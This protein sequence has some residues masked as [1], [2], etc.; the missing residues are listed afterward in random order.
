MTAPKTLDTPYAPPRIFG[1]EY[2]AASLG[3]LLCVTLVA[4]EGMSVGVV[5]PAISEELDALAC[6]A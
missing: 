5:M 1:S 6:T 3:I 4:F 2:R